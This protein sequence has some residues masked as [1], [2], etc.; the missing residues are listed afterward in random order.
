M[1][2][3]QALNGNIFLFRAKLQTIKPGRPGNVLLL[4]VSKNKL[5]F[6]IFILYE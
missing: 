2:S 4:A 5:G 1:A 6:M 3:Q